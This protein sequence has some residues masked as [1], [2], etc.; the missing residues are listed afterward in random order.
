MVLIISE[1]SDY[2]TTQV[3]FWLIKQNIEFVRINDSDNVTIQNFSLDKEDVNFELICND[4]T[5]KY[6]DITSVY[7]RRGH[8]KIHKLIVENLSNNKNLNFCLNQEVKI[9]K[10]FIHY[11]LEQ[12]K[13]IGRYDKRG[14]NKLKT[15]HYATKCGLDI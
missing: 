10:E 3:I 1:S 9:L 12:K 14:L 7:Y 15:L 11:L 2:T 5:I 8:L 4:K 6:S 13:S